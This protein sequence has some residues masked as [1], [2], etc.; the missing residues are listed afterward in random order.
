V[1]PG[2]EITEVG[3]FVPEE[4][5]QPRSNILHHGLEDVVAG[6]R[7]VVRDALPRIN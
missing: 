5:P 4:I 7:G 3:W 6:R 2:R 1:P